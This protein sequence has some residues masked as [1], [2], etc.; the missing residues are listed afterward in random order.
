MFF[1]NHNSL[2]NIHYTNARSS[3]SS[4]LMSRKTPTAAHSDL[5]P[6]VPDYSPLCQ[7]PS[8]TFPMELCIP[9]PLHC[10]SIAER[11]NKQPN[12]LIAFP[13]LKGTKRREVQIPKRPGSSLESADGASRAAGP[14]H[15]FWK[16]KAKYRA[17]SF[18]KLVPSIYWAASFHLQP[19]L[20]KWS[21]YFFTPT[22]LTW[23]ECS[24]V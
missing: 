14:D 7:H 12:L 8:H 11:S 24:E 1:I 16:E 22:R 13:K 4:L 17:Q 23:Q 18:I 5:P 2:P 9:A 15:A 6:N 10:V 19:S 20:E 21:E 3:A